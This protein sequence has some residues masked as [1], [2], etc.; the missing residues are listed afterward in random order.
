M[1]AI[2]VNVWVLLENLIAASSK[3]QIV[4]VGPKVKPH[5]E[6][7]TVGSSSLSRRKFQENPFDGVPGWR[8]PENLSSE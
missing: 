7:D 6:F 8:G 3:M 1:G 4:D 5:R 2:F